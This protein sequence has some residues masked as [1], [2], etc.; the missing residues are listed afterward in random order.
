MPDFALPRMPNDISP[1]LTIYNG[2]LD[3]NIKTGLTI[4]SKQ[5]ILYKPLLHN[6]NARALLS[7]FS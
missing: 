7:P 4:L 2:L 5:I 6:T 3:F 1:L